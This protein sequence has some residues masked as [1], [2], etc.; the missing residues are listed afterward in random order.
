MLGLPE[1]YVLGCQADNI[2]FT[3]DDAGAG[4]AG[5]DINADIEVLVHLDLFARISGCLPSTKWQRGHLV[6]E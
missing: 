3:I 1:T 5:S 4:T 2:A 6:Q